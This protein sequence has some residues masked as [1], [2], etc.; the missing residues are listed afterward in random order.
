MGCH[1]EKLITL[2]FFY[3]VYLI[4]YSGIPVYGHRSGA[5]TIIM[6]TYKGPKQMEALLRY[7]LYL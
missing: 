3:L 4:K 2:I 5:D 1:R 7:I 6:D